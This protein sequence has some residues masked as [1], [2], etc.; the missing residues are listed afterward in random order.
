MGYGNITGLR[1]STFLFSV[2]RDR[3]IIPLGAPRIM[4]IE[5]T[6]R[7][8]TRQPRQRFELQGIQG[9]VIA[10]GQVADGPAHAV[11]RCVA[12]DPLAVAAHK[13]QGV[14]APSCSPGA[15]AGACPPHGPCS[16]VRS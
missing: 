12:R 14:D 10:S 13:I 9:E 6:R 8:L 2:M 5:P 15:Y 1:A 11:C 3:A 16:A 7:K 4:S